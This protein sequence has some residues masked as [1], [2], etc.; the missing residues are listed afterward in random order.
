MSSAVVASSF[1]VVEVV[2]ELEV[3][4]IAPEILK[5]SNPEIQNSR[6]PEFHKKS[7]HDFSQR[8][9]LVDS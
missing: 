9:Y 8:P 1:E 6:I 2:E 7:R 5:S 3:V 4:E